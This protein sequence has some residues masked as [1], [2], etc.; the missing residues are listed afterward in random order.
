MTI[1]I[2]TSTH[3]TVSSQ[4]RRSWGE[5]LFSRPW[6]PWVSHK[7]VRI[8]DPYAYRLYPNR[9]IYIVHPRLAGDFAKLAAT[10]NID[11]RRAHLPTPRPPTPTVNIDGRRVHLPTPRPPIPPLATAVGPITQKG[12]DSGRPHEK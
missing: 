2:I 12:N 7:E 4:V 8:P 10:V 11:G 9:D 5:R 1:Q 6:Q 3:L